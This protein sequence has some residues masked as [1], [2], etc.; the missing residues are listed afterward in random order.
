MMVRLAPSL[1][2]TLMPLLNVLKLG[3]HDVPRIGSRLGKHLM[4]AFNIIAL[5]LPGTAVTYQ[6]IIFFLFFLILVNKVSYLA[7]QGTNVALQ[8]NYN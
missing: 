7:C 5:S 1:P 8:A 6:V 3:N 4:D 2:L